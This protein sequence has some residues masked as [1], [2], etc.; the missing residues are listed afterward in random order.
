MLFNLDKKRYKTEV[1]LVGVTNYDFL[2]DSCLN[3]H[4]KVRVLINKCIENYSSESRSEIISRI[5]SR[6]AE[7]FH[8]ACFE[9]LLFNMFK[10]FGFEV[11][12][13]PE[14]FGTTK[15]P[16]FLITMRN[17]SK[18]YLE[19]ATIA[20]SDNTQ[21]EELKK[22][23][24]KLSND[25][26]AINISRISG[27]GLLHS[28]LS[29]LKGELKKWWVTKS[30]A[31]CLGEFYN[32][33]TS[34]IDILFEIVSGEFRISGD[35]SFVQFHTQLADK[36][37]KKANRYGRLE[38][39]YIIAVT[40]RPS[41]Y[42][43]AV[44]YMQGLI[45]VAIY[46]GSVINAQGEVVSC[47]SLWRTKRNEVNN[48]NVSGVL[49][50]DE[51]TVYRAMK[52]FKYVLFNNEDASHK[53]EDSLLNYFQ[54]LTLHGDNYMKRDGFALHSVFTSLISSDK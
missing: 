43:A 49:F 41:T 42:S 8:S 25:E 30:K 13:H 29:E 45:E 5:K 40:F 12:E 39:P 44:S 46:G 37:R 1:Q 32:Y 19:L 33:K 6:D 15:R 9:L 31:Q 48:R 38:Y 50:F 16:D 18:F 22:Y 53:L 36:L 11:E 27:R 14:V 28:E 51:L 4:H 7:H 20:E 23:I 54:T 26:F 34:D 21:I 2:D 47:E 35:V 24:S 17:G 52:P 3:E 10:C